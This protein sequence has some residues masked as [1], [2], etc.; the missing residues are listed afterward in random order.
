MNWCTMATVSVAIATILLAG[1]KDIGR[2]R[3][4]RQV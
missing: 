2:F 1:K 3:Q 4:M